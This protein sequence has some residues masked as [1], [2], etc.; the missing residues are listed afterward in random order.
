MWRKYTRNRKRF[1]YGPGHTKMCLLPYVNNKGA[2]RP[3]HARSL[4]GTFV[5]CCLDNPAFQGSGWLLWLGGLVWALPGRK[6]RKTR[7]RVMW[8]I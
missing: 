6:S 2:R 4:I 1:T 7:F 8:L 3:A 5:V